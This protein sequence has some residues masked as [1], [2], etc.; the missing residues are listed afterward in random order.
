M[1]LASSS[2]DWPA[3]PWIFDSRTNASARVTRE[4][5]GP[6]ACCKPLK[7]RCFRDRFAAADSCLV[8]LKG[9]GRG[10]DSQPHPG[11]H[12]RVRYL[13]AYQS[14]APLK[15]GI[16]AVSATFKP[17]LRAYQSAAP[18]KPVGAH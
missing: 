7:R 3:W 17:Y 8:V 9:G 16:P 13:R 4:T 14:A 12:L 5:P 1:P 18:L 6:L 11:K 2:S 10:I 15:H